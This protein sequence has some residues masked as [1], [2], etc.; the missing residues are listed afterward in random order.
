VMIMPTVPGPAPLRTHG[1]DRV[2]A[3]RQA[4]L[5][6]TTPAAIGGLPAVSVPLLTVPSLLGPAP[7]GVCLVSRPGTDIALVRLARRLA[8]LVADPTLP[9]PQ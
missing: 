6:M 5:R 3:V 4:T 8:R 2:D 1:G 7:V 9:E